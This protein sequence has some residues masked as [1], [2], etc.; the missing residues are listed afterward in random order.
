M[1]VDE[2]S[3]MCISCLMSILGFDVCVRLPRGFLPGS[4]PDAA[5]SVGALLSV[6]TSRSKNTLDSWVPA[7]LLGVGRIFFFS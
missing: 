6:F 5:G 4:L 1:R 7:A 2:S 3:S